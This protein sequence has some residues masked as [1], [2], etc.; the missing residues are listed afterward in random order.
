[1]VVITFLDITARKQAEEALRESETRYRS[2][3]E[4]ID[5]GFC[6]AEK[7]DTAPGEPSNFRYIAANP[8]MSTISG[9]S[10]FLEETE[11]EVYPSEPKVWWDIYDK[12]L[13]TG[14][15][16]RFEREL[17][18]ASVVLEVHAFRIGD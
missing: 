15:P 10:D 4:G 16:F 8:A 14:E 18:A 12:V 5:E 3:F 11:R 17:A 1:G 6:I 13:R 9:V 2:L 7:L